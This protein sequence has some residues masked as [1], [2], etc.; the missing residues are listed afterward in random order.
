VRERRRPPPATQCPW[1]YTGGLENRPELIERLAARRPLLG[2]RGPV[3]HRVRDPFELA[4]AL[5][6]NGFN[7]PALRSPARPP[8]SGRWLRK[9]RRSA[10]G[11]GIAEYL[12]DR[13]QPDEPTDKRPAAESAEYF[14]QWMPG[15]S[16][17]AVFV[18]AGGAARL[19]GVTRQLTGLPQFGAAAF[20]YCGSLTVR[21]LPVARREFERLG[22]CL[23]NTF[24]LCGLF[25]VDLLV[26]RS[27][28]WPVEVNPR[29]TAS[30]EVLEW[31][32]AQPI[33][34]WHV[35]ACRLARLPPSI[36]SR[37][38][39]KEAV[40]GKAVVFARADG[41]VT[42]QINELADRL[43]HRRWPRLAD[44]PAVGQR[45]AEG[46]PIATVF[47]AASSPAE[48]FRRLAHLAEAVWNCC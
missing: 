32:L 40:R 37:R 17:S 47:A 4:R 7:V 29:Y 8:R 33:L 5:K 43:Q 11:Q 46:H 20:R 18:A 31:H 16:Y 9:P 1:L 22:H 13:E 25:G 10:G 15:P 24:P 27:R 45:I 28:L 21:R 39:G 6:R 19:V 3:L 38:R 36:H 14:Q 41:R 2:N 26:H 42:S 23:S 48:T 44:V 30:C 34:R 35:D 12:P